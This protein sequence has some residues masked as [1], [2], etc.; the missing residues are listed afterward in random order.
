MEETEPSF[1][2]QVKKEREALEKA[3]SEMKQLLL[4]AQELKAVEILSGKTEA[5]KKAEEKKP[6][7]SPVDYALNA[8]KGKV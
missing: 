5:G 8:L 7:V 2:E 4:K 6:E 1:L 3:N